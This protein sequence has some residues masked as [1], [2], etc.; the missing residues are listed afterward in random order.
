M[1]FSRI[2]SEVHDSFLAEALDEERGEG[3]S[4]RNDVS[5]GGTVCARAI[6]A[7]RAT[8]TNNAIII[9]VVVVDRARFSDIR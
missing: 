6:D 5:E 8:V 3:I 9:F 1:S 4:A 2:V 7:I